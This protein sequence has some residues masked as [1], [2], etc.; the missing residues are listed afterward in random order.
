MRTV[1][2]LLFIVSWLTANSQQKQPFD[3][4]LAQQHYDSAY[5]QLKTM[6]EGKAPANFKHAVFITEN[7][8]LDNT[9]NYLEF[10]TDISR[11]VVL[12]QELTRIA[13]LDY[14]ERDKEEVNKYWSVFMVMK[15]LKIEE[16][17]S[18]GTFHPITPFSYDFNDFFGEQ[19]WTKMFVTKLLKTKSGNC[20]SLPFLYKI[21]CE[22][23]GA[24]AYL[25]MAPNHIYIK[26]YSKK[27]GW[28][29]TE[30]TSGHFPIDAW[31]MA[32]G[33]V[34]LSAVQNGIYMDTLSAKQS[35]AVC[36][37]D[38]AS[39]Y[40]R[41]LGKHAD[42]GF[43]M[44]CAEKALQYYPSYVNAMILKAETMKKQFE[45]HMAKSNAKYPVDA[46]SESEAKQLFDKMEKLYFHIHKIGYRMMPK[47][48]YADWLNDL[49]KER[50]KYQN[51]NVINDFNSS[52]N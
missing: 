21:L 13:K 29:N 51:Q 48:M 16:K 52:K 19:D 46:F 9:A 43:I 39:G 14:E 36:M 45:S 24:K 38:L 50:Q 25:A 35:I 20:H 6:L 15:E 30:L 44:K 18:V 11:L 17:D 23:L 7:A 8:Y 27:N 28:Y 2:S 34:H 41:K 3:F 5:R 1:L 22:E 10:N 12:C 26:H 49:S 37:V 42:S 47:E 32:S 31:I 33:Y 40:A 4:T